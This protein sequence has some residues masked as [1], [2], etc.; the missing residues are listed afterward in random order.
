MF[1]GLVRTVGWIRRQPQGVRI[2]ADDRLGPLQLGDS[3]AVDGLCLTVARVLPDGF[4]ADVSEETLSRSTLAAKAA[5][6]GAV[7]LEPA[8]RLSDRLGGHLVS[9]HVDATGEVIDVRS[10]AR[11]WRLEIAWN[12]PGYGRYICEKGSI[13]VDGVSLTVAGAG[14]GGQS[15]WVA[16]IPHTWESTTLRQLTSGAAVN[17]E[18]DL[19]ARY[20][21]R[22]LQARISDEADHNLNRDWLLEHGWG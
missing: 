4:T 20:A 7:N 13:A 18:V 5:G 10:L 15:F 17:L 12:A 1:T 19:L 2:E 14:H 8:L 21:E 11:S 9:G 3:V 16:V 6:G 22:L